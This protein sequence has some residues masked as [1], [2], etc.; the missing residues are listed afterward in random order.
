VTICLAL[1]I[2]EVAGYLKHIVFKIKHTGILQFIQ[3]IIYIHN[4]IRKQAA[5]I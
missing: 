5:I 3:D 4:R 1:W 2:G